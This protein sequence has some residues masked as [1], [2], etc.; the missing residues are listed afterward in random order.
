MGFAD[1]T[2]LSGGF[3]SPGDGIFGEIQTVCF[4]FSFGSVGNA[5]YSVVVELLHGGED[6][7]FV[8]ECASAG[9]H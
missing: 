6:C 2:L 7:Y 1:F 8:V 3:G 5:F 9:G 4:G